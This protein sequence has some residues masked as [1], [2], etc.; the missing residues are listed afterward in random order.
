MFHQILTWIKECNISGPDPFAPSFPLHSL[1][2]SLNHHKPDRWYT[3]LTTECHAR[4]I[5]KLAVRRV[6][7]VLSSWDSTS[8]REETE[9]FLIRVW[10][11]L[12]SRHILKTL[13]G[14]L[15][16][17]PNRTIS[18]SSGLGLLQMVSKANTGRCASREAKP[19]K[20]WTRGGVPTRTLGP[21]GE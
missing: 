1:K 6:H 12:P 19:Q 7:K 13:R 10:K 18:A 3:N 17:S 21:E 8:V 20:G 2:M 9:T 11:P 4:F 5:P 16:K 15:K 14:S